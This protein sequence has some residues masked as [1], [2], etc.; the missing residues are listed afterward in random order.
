[1]PITGYARVDVEV[2]VKIVSWW[3]APLLSLA[4]TAEAAA[5][6]ILALQ[7]RISEQATYRVQVDFATT[8]NDRACQFEDYITGMWIAQRQT[9]FFPAQIS[10]K[11]HHARIDLNYPGDAVTCGW[12][13]AVISICVGSRS[14]DQAPAY[15]HALYVMQAHGGSEPAAAKM[16]CDTQSWVCTDASG[17]AIPRQSVAGFNKP[18]ALDIDA[19]E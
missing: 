6:K 17:S 12:Q 15:C 8:V 1:M 19:T 18:V 3:V 13:P 9:Q 11:T 10:G 16:Y 7:G 4:V 5:E 2:I 14:A